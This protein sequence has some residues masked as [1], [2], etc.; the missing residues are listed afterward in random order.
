MTD[1]EIE[2]LRSVIH[3]DNY[4]SAIGKEIQRCN[5]RGDLEL[6]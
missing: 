1:E 4:R 3:D 2:G 6:K 5:K